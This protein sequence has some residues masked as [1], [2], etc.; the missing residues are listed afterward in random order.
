MFVS[1]SCTKQKNCECGL[2]GRFIYYEEPQ[3]VIY[4]GDSQNKKVNA[5]FI[6]NGDE[7]V[8]DTLLYKYYIVGSIPKSFQTQDTVYVNVCLK[9]INDGPYL[10]AGTSDFFP[11]EYSI[12][13]LK[14]IE[15]T[16]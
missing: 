4:C 8:P 3:E 15:K 16:K 6:L 5:L 2:T 13:K 10:F 9:E 7:G 1:T 12:Y 11:C 14:C